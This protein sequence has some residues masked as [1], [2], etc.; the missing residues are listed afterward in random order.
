MGSTGEFTR[1]A[2]VFGT[3]EVVS[4]SLFR[5]MLGSGVERKGR[6]ELETISRIDRRHFYAP[7]SL[8]F[9]FGPSMLWLGFG[10]MMSIWLIL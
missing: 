5:S 4:A 9:G 7:C 8:V 1:L 6:K 2:S 3:G 10:W